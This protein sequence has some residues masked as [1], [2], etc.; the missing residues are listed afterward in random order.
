MSAYTTDRF[1]RFNSVA[2]L[3]GVSRSTINRW[4]KEGK[5]PKRV[6]L[7][8]QAIAWRQSEIHAYMENP[9]EHGRAIGTQLE[10]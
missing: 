9:F 2:Q 8:V 3:I 6:R 4:E 5:F 10:V 1:L 7:G